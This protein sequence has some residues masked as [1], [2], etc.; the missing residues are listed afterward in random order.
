[1][2]YFDYISSF[3]RTSKAD[4]GLI[5]MI[6][7]RF[8][9]ITASDSFGTKLELMLDIEHVHVKT[10]LNLQGLLDGRPEDLVHDVAGIHQHLNR[11]TLELEDFFVPRWT[12]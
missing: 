11:E 12:A 2:G 7:D 5:S 1:M 3:P 4:V 10:P 8:M 6:V 9:G